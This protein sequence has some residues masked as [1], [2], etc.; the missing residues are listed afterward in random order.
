M[1]LNPIIVNSPTLLSGPGP[2][3]SLEREEARTTQVLFSSTQRYSTFK[4]RMR[5]RSPGR[6][7]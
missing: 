4:Q 5:R 6:G 1:D 7:E 2:S 3:D